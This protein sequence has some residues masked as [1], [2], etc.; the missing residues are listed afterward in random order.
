MTLISKNVAFWNHQFTP[1][2]IYALETKDARLDHLP[3]GRSSPMAT[4][5]AVTG[6]SRVSPRATSLFTSDAAHRSRFYSL[7]AKFLITPNFLYDLIVP[8]WPYFV[9]VRPGERIGSDWRNWLDT[10]M[11]GLRED[12]HAPFDF[13][14][15]F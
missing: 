11:L 2:D 14:T 3:L 10:R 5:L 15:E 1:H 8:N 7:L 12:P 6:P 4:E 13:W 9:K